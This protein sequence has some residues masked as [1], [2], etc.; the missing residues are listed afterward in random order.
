MKRFLFITLITIVALSCDKDSKCNNCGNI[1]G[2]FVTMKVTENDLS[3]YEGLAQ[4]DGVT[5]GTCIKA[6]IYN[7]ELPLKSVTILDACCCEI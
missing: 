3:K 7:E 4:M 2:G 5:V 6:Y 1:S